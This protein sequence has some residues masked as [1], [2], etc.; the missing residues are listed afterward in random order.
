MLSVIIRDRA[1][2]AKWGW[3]EPPNS[4]YSFRKKKICQNFTRVCFVPLTPKFIEPVEKIQ[5]N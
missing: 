3:A 5:M 2:I 4:N 1:R